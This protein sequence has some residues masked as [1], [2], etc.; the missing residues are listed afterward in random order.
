MA[1]RGRS[2]FESETESESETETESESETETE[3]ETETESESE[4][5]LVEREC[6][7][8]RFAS[9]GFSHFRAVLGTVKDDARRHRRLRRLLRNP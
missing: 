9:L 4:Q 3:T 8:G 7:P 5:G 2:R 6:E 1:L